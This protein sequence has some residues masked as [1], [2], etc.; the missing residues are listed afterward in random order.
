MKIYR[1]ITITQVKE[2]PSL[3]IAEG[4]TEA[5]A[6]KLLAENLEDNTDWQDEESSLGEFG[7]I[8]DDEAGIWES[9][10]SGDGNN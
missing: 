8:S 1:Y 3:T 10:G 5:D 7:K 9:L 4:Q 6:V 2:I